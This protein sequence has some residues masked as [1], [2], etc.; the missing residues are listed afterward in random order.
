MMTMEKTYVIKGKTEPNWI[1]VD[2]KDQSLG[3]LATQIA[4]YILGKHKP[5]Y[6]P[7][8]DM[9]D[10]VVVINAAHLSFTQKRLEEKMYY[11]H[12]SYPGGLKEMTLKDMLEKHPERVLRKAV[13]GMIP[14]NKLGRHLIKRL[15][16]YP[17][18]E[19]AHEAQ[20]PQ[21]VA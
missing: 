2:A 14:H 20:N 7:G 16:I 9:G 15:R 10:E 18:A 1:L 3:R 5:T 6:T 21:L 19:H 8:V 12:T 13:W 4:Q 11:W 17:E